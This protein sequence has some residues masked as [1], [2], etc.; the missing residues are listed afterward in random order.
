MSPL[1]PHNPT[2]RFSGLADLYA[3]CRPD[4]PTAALDAIIERCRLNGTTL[5][6][7]V[8][9]GTGISSRQFAARGIPVLGIEPNDEMRARA[10]AIASPPGMPAPRYQ[11][12]RAEAT[13]L[14]DGVAH[15]VLAAQAFHWFDAD[16][17]LREFARILRPDGWVALLWNER[18]E[19]DPFTAAYGA[20]IRTAPETAIVE[21]PRQQAGEA[22]LHSPLFR[23]AQRL[24]FRHEQELDEDG[25]LGRAF[26]ASYA[27]REP[28]A[29]EAFAAALRRVVAEHQQAG[30]VR[31]VY[32]TSVFLARKR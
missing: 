6:V 1:E 7:D 24:D 2:G 5:L 4:Y 27:P 17:A 31:L 10:E 14:P 18:D 32:Q 22:L 21:G 9:C 3:R 15:V 25:V 20:V 28:A 19:S 12:G 30:K 13:G 16:A 23:D 11:K 29:A 8:G 26:S